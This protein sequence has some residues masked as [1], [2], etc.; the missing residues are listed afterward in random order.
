MI[1]LLSPAKTT[2]NLARLLGDTESGVRAAV[3]LCMLLSVGAALGWIAL[4]CVA[5]E[6]NPGSAAVVQA[7]VGMA[8][9]LFAGVGAAL[10]AL[11][12]LAMPLRL[13][14]LLA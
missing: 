8:A 14:R 12:T 6:G 11:G 5:L 2:R 1:E 9:L 3:V 10:R 7:L 4:Q 13:E